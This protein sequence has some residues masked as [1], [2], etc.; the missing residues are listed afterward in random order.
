MGAALRRAARPTMLK[1]GL[2][3]LGVFLILA[4]FAPWVAP[5][6]PNSQNLSN[7]LATP[8][9]E[10]WFGTDALGRDILSRVVFGARAAILLVIPAVLVA[11]LV[12]LPFGLLS[13]YRGGWTDRSM[14]VVAEALLTFPSIVLAIILVAVLGTGSFP[15][16]VALVVTQVPQTFRYV[17]G[18]T[19]QT[20]SAEYVLASRA[21]GSA[22]GFTV[23]RHILPNIAGP[24]VV[25][26]SLLASEAFLM[27]AA[28]GF[29]GIGVQPPTAEWGTMLNEARA[30]FTLHPH[31]MVFPGLAIAT[32]ILAFNILG[33][34][35]RDKLDV[36]S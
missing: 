22:T 17:R 7:S 2:G 21:S 14:S 30:D 32:L 25:I 12:A 35:L 36:R 34:A 15:L 19:S 5:S 13:G 18:F 24:L 3:I 10:H 6:D 31:V 26:T 16:L 20:A 4:V 23:S 1:V 27:I 28:L 29:L 11:L 8:S 9:S 33:D